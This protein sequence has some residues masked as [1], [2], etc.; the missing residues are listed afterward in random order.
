MGDPKPPDITHAASSG[1][2][3]QAD[4]MGG[5]GDDKVAVTIA[6]KLRRTD[7]Y[8]AGLLAIPID[9]LGELIVRKGAG[10]GH[11]VLTANLYYKGTKTNHAHAGKFVTYEMTFEDNGLG[12]WSDSIN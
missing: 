3:Y 12:V 4:G 6:G 1:Y 8:L 9:Q 7:K 10:I 11:D 5:K 2:T